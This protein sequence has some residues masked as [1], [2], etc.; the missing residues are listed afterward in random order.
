MKPGNPPLRLIRLLDQVR[1]RIRYKHYSLST[2]KVY[3]YRVRFF[4]RWHGRNGAMRHP[5]EMG[6]PEVEAIP[7]MPA[8]PG[9]R[10]RHAFDGRRPPNP[11]PCRHR[12]ASVRQKRSA[13]TDQPLQARPALLSNVMSTISSLARLFSPARSASVS[14]ASGTVSWTFMWNFCSPDIAPLA[15]WVFCLSMLTLCCAS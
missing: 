1:E 15:K 3:P 8:T 9:V 10:H 5:R 11:P 7:T 4:I 13:S 6:S 14:R 2:E 12:A